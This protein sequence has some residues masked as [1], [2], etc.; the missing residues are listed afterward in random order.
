MLLLILLVCAVSALAGGGH[1]SRM[2]ICGYLPEPIKPT[3]F[4]GTEKY[5]IDIWPR[6]CEVLY[7]GVDDDG[8]FFESWTVTTFLEVTADGRFMED[9]MMRVPI[10]GFYE[11]RTLFRGIGDSS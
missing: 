2:V 5:Y 11:Y 7:S 8:I 3:R 6:H 9:I 4:N 1:C 10:D